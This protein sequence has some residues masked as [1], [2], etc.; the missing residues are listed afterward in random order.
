MKLENK[1]NITKSQLRSICKRKRNE[2][3]LKEMLD[4]SIAN[5]L[6]H[7]DFYKNAEQI[8]CYVSMKNEISTDKIINRA[9]SDCKR[10]AVPYCEN[11]NGDMSFYY[12]NSL[13]ELA[14]GS[15]DIREPKPLTEKLVNSFDN[16]IIIL[17]GLSFDKCGNRLGYGKGYYDR[18]LQK[19]PLNSVGLCYNS[20]IA[21]FI[22]TD[23]YDKRVSYIITESQIISCDN[24][25][26]NG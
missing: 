3:I 12:I 25:G 20:L 23:E 14:I 22:P 2:L 24:G 11:A 9:L 18:F 15:F 19:H 21:D 5:R 16:S 7:S 1:S 8:L 26:K 4:D 10:V 13:N 6:I 17:P